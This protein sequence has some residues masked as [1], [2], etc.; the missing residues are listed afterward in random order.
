MFPPI[1]FPSSKKPRI[2]SSC[3]INAVK[4]EGIVSELRGTA[5][6]REASTPALLELARCAHPHEFARGTILFLEGDAVE[7]VLVL[8][9][10]FARTYCFDPRRE[11]EFTIGTY[12]ARQ[13][14]GVIAAFL[15]PSR[16][17]ASAEMLE[18]G[19]VLRVDAN[20]VRNLAARD[21]AFT[22]LTL[23]HVA[24]RHAALTNRISQLVFADLDARVAALLLEHASETGWLLPSNTLLA[25]QLGTVPELVSRK[26]GEFYRRGWIRLEKRRV[27][28]VNVD[29]LQR[30]VG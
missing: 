8:C 9:S 16:F 25:A 3:N 27:F 19:V 28:V 5:W 29:G 15:E 1:N 4:L 30:A 24:S 26:L 20:A 13:S 21:A 22:A 12:G 18:G 23:R 10:G 11:R 7:S 14:L 6:L 17:T 2:S